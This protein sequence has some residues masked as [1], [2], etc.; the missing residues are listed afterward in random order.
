[1][2]FSI[3]LVRPF[4]ATLKIKNNENYPAVQDGVF[5]GGRLISVT[6]KHSVL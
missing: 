1:M 6:M 4:P 3:I 2:W 5:T